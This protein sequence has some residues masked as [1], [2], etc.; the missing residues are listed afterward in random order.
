MRIIFE[1]V[2]TFE[3]EILSNKEKIKGK[4]ELFRNLEN[5]EHY[6]FS[7]S[8]AEMFRLIPSFPSD[9]KGKPLHDTD[10]TLWTERTFPG[11]RN[12][13]K[14]FMAKNETEA[15]KIALSQVEAFYNHVLI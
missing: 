8:E 6:R 3:F 11:T 4:L 5:S 10:E 15:V 1:L 7:T 12:A 2:K 13:T 9:D 14:E